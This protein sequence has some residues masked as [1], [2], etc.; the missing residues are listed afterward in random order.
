MSH[1]NKVPNGPSSEQLARL[2]EQ[3]FRRYQKASAIGFATIPPTDQGGLSVAALNRMI[4][5][6]IRG[7]KA[8]EE[9]K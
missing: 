8:R 3:I 4:E 2:F 9:A 7:V 6:A 1:G 5:G